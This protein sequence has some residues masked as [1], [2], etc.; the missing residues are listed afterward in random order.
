[1][2]LGAV[3]VSDYFPALQLEERRRQEEEEEVRRLRQEAV[4]KAQPIR[5]YAPIQIL[6]S[7]RPITNPVSPKFSKLRSERHKE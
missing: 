6:P 4:H 1:M 7:D 2:K 5:S 3:S